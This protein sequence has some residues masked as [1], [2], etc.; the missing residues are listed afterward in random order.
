M[1]GGPNAEEM[2]STL[3]MVAN[4]KPEALHESDVVVLHSCSKF[5]HVCIVAHLLTRI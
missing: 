5:A 1:L 2:L 3:F 4:L